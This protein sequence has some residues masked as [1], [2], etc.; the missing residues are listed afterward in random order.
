MLLHL[1]TYEK[2]EEIM[3]GIHIPHRRNILQLQ[4]TFARCSLPAESVFMRRVDESEGC[5]CILIYTCYWRTQKYQH[6][7]SVTYFN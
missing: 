3:P 7:E 6:Q 5:G 1:R 2:K 4:N